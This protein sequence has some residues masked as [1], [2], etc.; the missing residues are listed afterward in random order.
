MPV[1]TFTASLLDGS[2]LR[3]VGRLTGDVNS[4]L[5]QYRL[6]PSSSHSL[7]LR[8]SSIRLMAPSLK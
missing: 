4:W 6:L 7:M 3:S 8:A 1:L 2:D 5:P